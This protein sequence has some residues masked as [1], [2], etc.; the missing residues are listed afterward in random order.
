MDS[1]GQISV[2]LLFAT[3][4]AMIIIGSFVALITGGTEKTQTAE[5][6]RAR[7]VGERIA[8]AIN[9]VYINGR[10]YAINLT[11]PATSDLD[12]TADVT[13]TGYVNVAYQG[14]T[15]SIRLIPRTNITSATLR[16]GNI[17]NIRNN[18]GTITITQL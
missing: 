18:N 17:Y 10:G 2:D 16:S 4:V 3:L 11:M 1:R 5:F 13:S 6:G 15:T 9:T 14:R 8:E 7:M 12:M